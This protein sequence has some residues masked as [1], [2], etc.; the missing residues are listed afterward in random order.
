MSAFVMIF[1]GRCGSTYLMEA[2][3]SHPGITCCFEHLATLKR[4]K[5]TAAEQ[6]QWARRFLID[7]KGSDAQIRGFKTKLRDVLDLDRF[8]RMLREIG[9]RIIHLQRRNTIKATVSFFNSV[10]LRK[11]TGDH[12]L[13]DRQVDLAS[14]VIDRDEFEEWLKA[15][16]Q[17]ATYP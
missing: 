2:L 15:A 16:E 9:A 14:I 4:R 10:R 13:Y 17:T 1:Q 6:L 12:N 5:I 7:G 8:G 11:I 3:D